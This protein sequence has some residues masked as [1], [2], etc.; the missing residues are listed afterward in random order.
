MVLSDSTEAYFC[1]SRIPTNLGGDWYS[2]HAA[3][4]KF[5]QPSH[6]FLCLWIA[7]EWAALNFTWSLDCGDDG[8]DRQRQR[9]SQATRRVQTPDRSVRLLRHIISIV[10]YECWQRH[11][12]DVGQAVTKRLR[13]KPVSTSTVGHEYL[14]P[15]EY[16]IHFTQVLTWLRVRWMI[17]IPTMN[18]IDTRIYTS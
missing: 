16:E 9:Q 1:F 18:T 17:I 14:W 11:Q 3:P 13:D 2:S 7:F 12:A 8:G 4:D 5:T 15:Y 6:C 10:S